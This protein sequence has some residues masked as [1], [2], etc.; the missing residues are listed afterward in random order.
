MDVQAIPNQTVIRA[1]ESTENVPAAR[2]IKDVSRKIHKLDP[3]AAPFTLLLQLAKSEECAE[4]Q[5]HWIEEELA[6]KWSQVNAGAGYASGITAIVVD[7]A[8]Y[9]SV[10]DIVNVVRT[11]EKMRVTA[12]D[13]T[14]NTLTV[15]RGVG[16]TVAAAM[17]DNDD[18]QIIGNAYAEGSPLGLEKSN[19]EAYLYNYVQIFRHVYGETGTQ[20]ATTGY[21]GKTRPRLRAR[22]SIEHKMDI[23]RSALFGERAI[24][25]TNPNNP[26]RYTGGALYY[27]TDNVLDAGGALTA[28]E[29]WTWLQGVFQHL[30]E[31]GDSR[32]L[33]ASPLIVTVMDQF[34]LTTG[35]VQVN[36]A[37]RDK[38]FGLSVKQ[39]STSHGGFSIIKHRLL[40]N[41][42]G[43]SGYGGH[44]LLLDPSQWGYRHL[45]GRNTQL[46]VDVG[47]PGDDGYSDEFLTECGWKV[48]LSK[49]QGVLKGVT[50]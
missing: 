34:A 37:P 36:W 32:T 45:P 16:S 12:V 47:N 23:E 43:G 19:I 41:G 13:T 49:S 10:G 25:T 31:G 3:D 24:D 46:R 48:S 50:S 11:G 33:F 2:R 9:F 4:P 26:R 18:L 42:L 38:T 35:N 29:V 1:R 15:V 14:T 28:A 30:T 40:D 21:T 44:G 22:K 5:F 8:R 7:H 6:A 39:W 27:I 20:A 17:L